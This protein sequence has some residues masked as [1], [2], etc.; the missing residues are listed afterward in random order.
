MRQNWRI[1]KEQAQQD[2]R[3]PK[4]R[5]F[6]ATQFSFRCGVSSQTFSKIPSLLS[7]LGASLVKRA[8]CAFGRAEKFN[9]CQIPWSSVA[10]LYKKRWHSF[11]VGMWACGHRTL[12]GGL[13]GGLP[14]SALRC[15]HHCHGGTRVFVIAS[16]M[17][18]ATDA[19]HRT[20]ELGF[21][22][23]TSLTF[24]TFQI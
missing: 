4:N 20:L 15:G 10:L 24:C 22:S 1:P 21:A 8:H 16:V 17:V 6:S 19:A 11:S 7:P 2:W 23:C 5:Q 18:T 3:I 12:P 14:S 9:E 13:P